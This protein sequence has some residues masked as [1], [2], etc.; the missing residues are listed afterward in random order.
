M[1][2]DDDLD[3]DIDSAASMSEDYLDRVDASFRGIP[4]S[5]IAATCNTLMD[6]MLSLPAD[7][8]VEDI[9]GLAVAYHRQIRLVAGII[10]MSH[11]IQSAHLRL[12][13]HLAWDKQ[14]QTDWLR[15]VIAIQQD[16]QLPR[17]PEDQDA[18]VFNPFD[19][20]FDSSEATHEQ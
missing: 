9:A 13:Q 1:Y 3:F 6:S 19:E 12:M 5:E 4:N 18:P 20:L 10:E 8:I 14:K 15:F 17:L 16:A 2:S 7:F 11:A